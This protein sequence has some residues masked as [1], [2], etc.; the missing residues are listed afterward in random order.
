MNNEL[1]DLCD[2]ALPEWACRPLVTQIF[3]AAKV[4]GGEARIVGG[5]VRDWI[6]GHPVGDI[7]MAVNLPIET[8]ASYFSNGDVRVVETGLQHGTITLCCA[9]DSIQL[10]QTRVDL[11]TDGRHSVVVYDS[12]WSRDAARRDFTINAIYLGADGMIFDPLDGQSD[13]QAG[14]LQFVGDATQRLKEDALRILRYCR[15]LP[16]FEKAGENAKMANLLRENAALCADLSGE[17]IAEELR[18]IIVGGEVAVVAGFMR[19][20]QIDYSALGIKFN[21]SPLGTDKNFEKMLVQLGWLTGLAAII[22]VGSG[23]RLAKRLRLSRVEDRC[24]VR[25][26]A[27]ITDDELAMLSGPRWQQGAYHLGDLAPMLYA[28]QSWRNLTAID[29]GRCDELASWMPPKIPICGTDLLSHGVDN[30][31]AIGHMLREAEKR[32]VSSDFT[33]EKSA[34]LE[35]LL[36]N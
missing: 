17:R 36:G 29:T 11:E 7:D 30:G 35:W 20:T 34:L 4:L 16:R 9:E 6:T 14:R 33:L 10:T 5:A 13:L 22:P 31:P 12:D 1:T 21:L 18:Q 2:S 27:G 8:V 3:S 26:D 25:L 24:L 28:L 15:F 23:R 32:W 19:R